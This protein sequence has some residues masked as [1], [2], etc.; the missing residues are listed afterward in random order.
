MIRNLACAHLILLISLLPTAATARDDLAFQVTNLS[1]EAYVPRVE[2]FVILVDGSSSMRAKTHGIDKIDVARAAAQNLAR[3]IPP[4]DYRGGVRA[5]GQERQYPVGETTLLYGMDRY[6]Q[7]RARDAIDRIE[8]SYG[9]SPLATALDA[10]AHDLAGA[11]GETAVFLVSDGLEM[12]DDEVAA[13]RRLHQRANACIYAIQVGVSR[14]GTEMLQ[15]IVDAAGCGEVVPVWDLQQ[16]Q[17]MAHVVISALLLGDG[18]HDGVPDNKDRCLDTAAGTP[19]DANGCPPKGLEVTSDLWRLPVRFAFDSTVIEGEYQQALDDIAVYMKRNPHVRMVVEGHADGMGDATYNQRLS[20]R[21]AQVTRD[22]LV[23]RGV[24]A[25]RMSIEAF[26]ASQ[27]IADNDSRASR[28]KN[29]RTQFRILGESA[30]TS[31]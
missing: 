15:R 30:V 14:D 9:D 23:S 21:R 26:G 5:F 3:A 2:S 11:A 22:Y 29:R 7:S 1:S 19:V 28:A 12:G 6:S 31:R 25:D 13:A 17:A 24:A 20:E 10:A 8:C 16:K 18:D 27:P 4:L